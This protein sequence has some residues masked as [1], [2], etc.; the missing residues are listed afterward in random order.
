MTEPTFD[1]FGPIDPKADIRVGYIST[2]RGYVSGIN[3]C[4]ANAYAKKNPGQT[5]IFKPKRDVVKF[6]N[7]NQVNRLVT[8]P[9]LSGLDDSCPD[10][11]QMEGEPLPPR[12][13]F[14]GGGG[15]GVVGNPVI[16]DDGSVMAVHLVDGG[17]G[18]QYP[19][20]VEVRDDSGI[21]QGAVI[22]VSVGDIAEQL[23]YYDKE[24]DFEDYQICDSIFTTP[25]LSDGG[26]ES[27][28][29]ARRS[30]YGRR[31]SPDG[32]DLGKWVP[33]QYVSDGT[34]P[35]SDV[36]DEYIKKVRSSGENWWTTRM[37]PP[38][39]V[40]SGNKTTKEFYKV[41]DKTFKEEHA[42]NGTSPPDGGWGKFMNSY[43]I[44]PVP[45]SNAKPSDHAGKWYTFE[46]NQ[47]FPYDG[48]YTFRGAKDNRAKFY[49]D[50]Q[51]ISDLDNYTG[52]LT[53]IKKTIKG[54]NHTIRLDL[55]NIPIME[56][57][58]VQQKLASSSKSVTFNISSDAQFA[59]SIRIEGLDI[60]E[61]K[62]NKGAQINAKITKDIEFGRKYKVVL[63]SAQ[64]T[65]G[66][67]LRIRDQSILEMEEHTD[68]DWKDVVCAASAGY[69]HSISGNVCYFT[70][71]APSLPDSSS[72]ESKGSQTREIFNTV[73]YIGKANRKL[74]RTNVYNRGGFLNE[75]GVCPFDTLNLLDDNPYAGTHKIVWPNVEFP[76]DGNY[77]IEIEVD[78]NVDL[79][80]GDQVS[81]SKKGFVGDS[82]ES[83]GKLKLSRY[84]KQGRH[85]I[86]ADLFQKA[87]GVFGFKQPDGNKVQLTE[88][89]FNVS[90]NAGLAN[91][92]TVPGLFSV[93]KQHK[94]A[95]INENFARNVQAGKEYEVILSTSTWAQ[96]D[97]KLRIK[98]DGKRLE[99]EEWKDNDYNDLVCTITSGRFYNIQGNRCKF[100]VDKTI[101]GINPMALA[102]N[103][104][105][106]FSEKEIQAKRSWNQNPM[107]V[108]LTIDAPLPPIPQEPIPKQEGR[109]PNNPFW[110][111]RF[112]GGKEM[113]YPV[114][115]GRYDW[116]KTLNTYGISPLPPLSDKG[117]PKNDEGSF[118]NVWTKNFPYGG[119]YKAIME[120]DDFGELWID[121]KKIL[122]YPK[123]ANA[124]GV[125][126]KLFYISGPNS[127]DQPPA[128]HDIKVVVSNTKSEIK[129][130][131]NA[132]VFSTLDW[133]GGGN[134]VTTTETKTT[135]FRITSDAQFANGIKIP[136][137]DID[138]SKKYKGAQLSENFEREVQV[139]KVYEV[140]LWSSQSREGV[141]LRNKGE[142]VL[143]M[144][145]HS[146]NDWK[147]IVCS[148]TNGR[149]YD[150]KPGAN[151]A[152]CKYVITGT[153]KAS[154]ALASNTTREGITYSGPH[155]FHHQDKRWGQ[156]MNK[157]S[158]SPISSPTQS[159]SEPN[160]NILGTK[161]LIWKNVDFPQTGQY[162]ITFAADNNAKLFIGDKEILSASD[163]FKLD[164]YVD[165]P[166]KIDKGKFDIRVELFNAHHGYRKSASD[167]DRKFLSNPTGVALRI[168]TKLSVDS[169]NY[170]SWKENS[171][172]IGV[173][174]IPPPCPKPIKGK[175]KVKD[176]VVQD[177]GNGYKRDQGG[178]YPVE[179]ELTN[180]VI[181]DPG[182]N[183]N[184]ATDT[185]RLEPSNG[186]ELKLVCG[187]FGR[188]EAVDV[189]KP[190]RGFT[191]TPNVIID[192]PTGVNLEVAPQ[193]KIVVD[194]LPE[195]ERLIQVT[196][197]VGIKRTGYY[198]GRP[199]YGAVFYKD[200]IRYAG[201]YETAG[202]LIQIYDTMQESIDAEVTTPPSAILKQ[203]SDV[204]S[205]DPRLNLPG[206]P[207][208]LT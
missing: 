163:N 83:T 177:P 44:S 60:L 10:G 61:S 67:R 18:Y 107:G 1:I 178:G 16:G 28:T 146:D 175:G 53:P 158:V 117:D 195:P 147:D 97:I 183:Y 87:G 174:L 119:Y 142:S 101:K 162:Q 170:K 75:Y 29:A 68:N 95:Q 176:P 116:G 140:E 62:K 103:I 99:M 71:D 207:E 69:F 197:L 8:D 135:S 85:S 79:K 145:E 73:D 137:L 156:I 54:G 92:I 184:C 42:K 185:I 26:K 157:N 115:K 84:I 3:I 114:R 172:G 194:P 121:D 198:K 89:K 41:T 49:L 169:G 201:W 86:T 123:D 47:E 128:S 98:D 40:A 36:V 105:T 181:K 13:I 93:G 32:K 144:E 154:S 131:I 106:I 132:K 30:E 202:E 126:E 111:T 57:V 203:G 19:P 160:D 136:E 112:P 166:V 124:D 82:N 27:R 80:I 51:F 153:T 38:L 168:N 91:K 199:Y 96:E 90:T 81:I 50:N 180:I 152:T 148:A 52:K 23:E 120:V 190:G 5:F 2:D 43:A 193:Y 165:T 141:R 37:H 129:K 186:A 6:L 138:V 179:L 167:N 15:V 143:E 59:N 20:I 113:W 110:T 130:R 45:P 192:S 188:I 70:V 187:P 31:W 78:D 205:N 139:N 149:F 65:A 63:D 151:K 56:K 159:L 118:T 100:I 208:N 150:F 25:E 48:E 200:N 155:L 122:D 189:V 35:F 88:V 133:I 102:I 24:E 164:E 173:K 58:K 161:V 17:Y 14:M 74:W 77:E 206:T 125:A 46:W 109:C 104:R 64:S 12:M 182:I 191:A 39:Q 108:A 66:V 9:S 34:I 94:G 22:N 11:L 55:Y 72:T 204:S 127:P 21:G 33:Q 7:I 196:D 76:L 171:I 134:N 4:E